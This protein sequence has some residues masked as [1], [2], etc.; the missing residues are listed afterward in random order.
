MQDKCI[1]NF[2]GEPKILGPSLFLFSLLGFLF[3]VP[4]IFYLILYFKK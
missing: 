3:I 4:L 2:M 1:A